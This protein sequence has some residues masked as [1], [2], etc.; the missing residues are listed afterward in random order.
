MN[1]TYEYRLSP[2]AAQVAALDETLRLLRALYNA[3]LQERRDAWK[4]QGVS[5]TKYAQ[6]AQLKLIRAEHP[7]YKAIA[8]HLLQD[9]V[10]RNDLAFQSFFRRVKTGETP[11]FPRFKGRGQYVMRRSGAE[12]SEGPG[13]SLLVRL[14]GRSRRERREEHPPARA[15]PSGR[16]PRSGVSSENRQQRR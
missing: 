16:P 5:V 13:A 9:V 11:G 15:E 14:R 3:C 7:E 6:S 4:K 12:G 2:S 1:R 10:A 8:S